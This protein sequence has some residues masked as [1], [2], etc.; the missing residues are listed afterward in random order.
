MKK[1]FFCWIATWFSLI[2]VGHTIN[3]TPA[4][5]SISHQQP[6]G[7][8]KIHNSGKTDLSL[9][10]E[11]VRWEQHNG[12]DRYRPSQ[13]VSITPIFFDLPKHKT[14][15]IRFQLMNDTSSLTMQ[16]TYRVYI[17]QVL[18][19][20]DLHHLHVALHLSLPLFIQ[21]NS[22]HEQFNWTAHRLNEKQLIVQLHNTG[23]VALF[24]DKWQLFSQDNKPL[25]QEQEA[26]HYILPNQKRR[27]LVTL[28]DN[29]SI[30]V[31][32]SA[33]INEQIR[34]SPIKII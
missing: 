34:V 25:F 14:R 3:V 2:A 23:N 18:S 8:L 11:L 21:P 12:E 32:I 20:T 28:Q 10:I 22:V 26:L 17:K 1:L 5:L 24:T 19:A 13:S 30:P 6:V 7:V 31:Q 27:W 33:T 16:E 15:L 9:K 29:Q 4:R